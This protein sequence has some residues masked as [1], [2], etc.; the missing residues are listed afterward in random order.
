[1]IRVYLRIFVPC[2]YAVGAKSSRFY[3]ERQCGRN[4]LKR[5]CE[6]GLYP[7]LRGR[8]DQTEHLHVLVVT[9]FGLSN[10]VILLGQELSE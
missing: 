5:L 2:I 7:E 9:L 8:V 6:G 10:G 4:K 1:M 3:R